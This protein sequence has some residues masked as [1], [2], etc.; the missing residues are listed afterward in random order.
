MINVLIA[1]VFL[2]ASIATF[3]LGYRRVFQGDIITGLMY[4][5]LG[6]FLAFSFS[7]LTVE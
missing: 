6:S 5:A 4:I 3:I 7:G 2:I 1:T